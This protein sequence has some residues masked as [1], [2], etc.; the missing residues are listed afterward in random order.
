MEQQQLAIGKEAD[1]V[2]AVANPRVH[3][4]EL[5]RAPELL[6]P[7]VDL[8][9]VVRRDASLRRRED[10]VKVLDTAEGIDIPA[11][12]G[13]DATMVRQQRQDVRIEP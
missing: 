4:R 10:H 12:G 5:R 8:L 7:L 11:K 2:R 13:N 9:L 3:L 6:G 1:V